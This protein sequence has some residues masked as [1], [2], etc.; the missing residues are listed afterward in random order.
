MARETNAHITFDDAHYMVANEGF[1][2]KTTIPTGD[3]CMTKD[4]IT[5][6][7][8]VL[9][10]PISNYAAN[11]LVCY[12]DIQKTEVSTTGVNWI[13][14]GVKNASSN[15]IL[16]SANGTYWTE[17]EIPSLIDVYHVKHLNGKWF[18]IGSP[19]TG[20]NR[21]AYSTDGVTWTPVSIAYDLLAKMDYGNGRYVISRGVSNNVGGKFIH[22]TDG[23]N[24]TLDTSADSYDFTPTDMAY[25]NG[26]WIAVGVCDLGT[27]TRVLTSTNGITWSNTPNIHPAGDGFS[28]FYN[29]SNWLMG[30]DGYGS[31]TQVAFSQDGSTWYATDI[32]SLGVTGASC[33][34]TGITHFNGLWIVG[35]YNSTN[36][37]IIT[38]PDGLNWTGR[39]SKTNLF[40]RIVSS[41]N[42]VKVVFYNDTVYNSKDG[43]DYSSYQYLP[44]VE[45]ISTIA[46]RPYIPDTTAPVFNTPLSVTGQT[47]NSVSLAWA[48][49]DDIEVTGVQLYY[50]VVG[51]AN[52]SIQSLSPVLTSYTKSG[53]SDATNYEFKILAW[54]AEGNEA[55][56]N[57][58]STTTDVLTVYPITVSPSSASHGYAGGSTNA[59]VTCSSSWVVKSK[60]SWITITNKT[61]SGFTAISDP[62]TGVARSG[63]IRVEPS[64][65]SSYDILS[66]SQASDFKP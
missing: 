13:I 48:V 36:H 12:Q 65:G 19:T 10:D 31:G 44:N 50:R 6:C 16:T 43:V 59:T 9:T 41:S 34:V 51:N 35:V 47:Y 20:N 62:N 32:S 63:S 29:G 38:S 17:A 2:A 5:N 46:V 37:E 45:P 26:K 25:G 8:E 3:E 58:V 61:S 7:L 55:F 15:N 40:K 30:G 22:S 14:G 1:T 56:S 66:I 52:W 57:T 28:I 21:L 27:A 54:D 18:A 11:Q 39:G 23:I 49:S 4:A 60:P 24:W 53:L 42:K 64:N 33:Y